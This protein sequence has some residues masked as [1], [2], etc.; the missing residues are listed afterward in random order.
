MNLC[1]IQP[2]IIK[3]SEWGPCE[4]ESTLVK[5]YK[6]H[7]IFNI[8]NV[9]FLLKTQTPAMLGQLDGTRKAI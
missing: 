8:V 4:E 2:P 6:F 1:R 5:L 3:T 9:I 7:K